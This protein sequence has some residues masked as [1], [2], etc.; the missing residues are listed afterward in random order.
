MQKKCRSAARLVLGSVV[1]LGVMVSMPVLA[2]T[3]QLRRF[4]VHV[5]TTEASRPLT[6]AFVDVEGGQATL[7][8]TPAHQSL[9]VDTGW[10]DSGDRDADRIVAAAKHAG[11]DHID[12]LVI[13]H[14][15]PDHAGGVPALLARMPVR[16]VIDHGPNREL[17]TDRM[18]QVWNAYLAAVKR[19]GAQR[20][21]ARPGE[22]IPLRGMTVT[23]VSADA[24]VLQT[25]LPGAGQPNPYCAQSPVAPVDMTENEHSVGLVMQLGKLRVVDLGDL[26]SD[27]ERDLMCPVNRLG[28]ADVLVVS[29]HGTATSSSP[30]LVDALAPRIA[31]MDNGQNKGGSPR[32]WDTVEKSPRL[33]QLWQLHYSDAGGAAHNVPAAYIANLDGGT[34]G[35][36]LW[37]TA[38]PDGRITVKNLRLEK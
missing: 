34:D 5:E 27:R 20:V 29:H 35:N 22:Q 18:Q 2:Q 38:W 16:E 10:D 14:Y 33:E 30:A 21:L 3:Q 11:V 12:F 7:F 1:S 26:T 25:P 17:T 4:P 19:S 15:H 9:L 31:I 8:V 37:M 6:A 32:V 28:E 23:I 13:T 24:Q 36:A